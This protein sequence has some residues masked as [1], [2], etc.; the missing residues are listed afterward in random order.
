MK[1][2]QV[3]KKLKASNLKFEH[4]GILNISEIET[5]SLSLIKPW[6]YLEVS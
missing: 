2:D 1:V 5:F 4:S 6:I 3:G